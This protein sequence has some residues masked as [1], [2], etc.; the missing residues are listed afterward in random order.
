MVEQ[1][2]VPIESITELIRTLRGQRV[3]LDADMARL[4]GVPT[5]VLNQA[6]KRNAERFPEDFVFTLT[7]VEKSELVTNCDQFT[8]LKH[9]YAMPH[10]FTEHGALM[11]ANVLNSPKAVEMSVYVVRAFIQQRAML[12]AHV[13]LSLQLERLERKL[14]SSVNLLREHD[15]TLVAHESQIKA[16]IEAIN[17][18]R[19]PPAT[20]RREIG[21]RSHEE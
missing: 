14:I 5:K 11:A 7:E 4:Y 2:L 6:I 8:A 9:S 16:L 18:I 17:A 3:I 15:D 1:T 20:P 13:D 19:T 10:A 12:A 21:F